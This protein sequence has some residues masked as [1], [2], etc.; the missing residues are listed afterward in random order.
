MLFS[1][2]RVKAVAKPRTAEESIAVKAAVKKKYPQ[3]SSPDWGKPHRAVVKEDRAAM[4]RSIDNR[5]KLAEREARDRDLKPLRG[6][7][8]LSEDDKEAVS[9]VLRGRKP[10]K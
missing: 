4:K 1:K 8:D 6:Y 10:R 5:R 7:S 2:P 9:N 3:M